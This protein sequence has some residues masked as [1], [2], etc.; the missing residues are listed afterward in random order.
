M[1]ARTTLASFSGQ[2]EELLIK[3]KNVRM[4][5]IGHIVYTKQEEPLEARQA[6][7]GDIAHAVAKSL[8]QI[9]LGRFEGH[10]L[11]LMNRNRPG[12]AQGQL[13]YFG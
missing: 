7:Q 5:L 10:S 3:T 8:P 1:H 2:R 11:A 13:V 9:N 6:R 4:K 12:Q